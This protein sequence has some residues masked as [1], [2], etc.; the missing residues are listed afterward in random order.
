MFI[1]VTKSTIITKYITK[2][3]GAQIERRKYIHEGRNSRTNAQMKGKQIRGQIKEGKALQKQKLPLV[4]LKHQTQG[5]GSYFL[6]AHKIQRLLTNS[7]L[8]TNDS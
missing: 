5:E 3:K 7:G 2:K 8:D 4:G 6:V 1:F